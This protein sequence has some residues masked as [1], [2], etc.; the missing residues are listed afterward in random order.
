MN[1]WTGAVG[2][3]EG[4]TWWAWDAKRSGQGKQ[5]DLVAIHGLRPF[6]KHFW[7]EILLKSGL[8]QVENPDMS[9]HQTSKNPPPT[10]SSH[11]WSSTR[12]HGFSKSFGAAASGAWQRRSSP[13][14]R[15][16]SCVRVF[17]FLGFI[18]YRV[19]IHN[20]LPPFMQFCLLLAK[21][22]RW[23]VILCGLQFLTKFQRA[24]HHVLHI[25]S[26]WFWFTPSALEATTRL[27]HFEMYHVLSKAAVTSIALV[28]I[29][30]LKT[31][32]RNPS[33]TDQ[34]PQL[35][36]SQRKKWRAEWKDPERI[37]SWGEFIFRSRGPILPKGHQSRAWG[38]GQRGNS[39]FVKFWASSLLI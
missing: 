36:W 26:G 2:I 21:C 18:V 34:R 19:V 28:E 10:P 1:P 11:S 23:V 22:R 33:E 8:A 29:H 15:V 3:F 35:P 12:R 25:H 30:S 39:L 17:E 24:L 32:V 20:Y 27:S 9:R 4:A 37:G 16:A 6:V 13:G 31:N 38:Q 7:M 14:N 5:E